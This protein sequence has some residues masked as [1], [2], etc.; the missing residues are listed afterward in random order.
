METYNQRVEATPQHEK[1]IENMNRELKVGESQFHALLDKK[2]DNSM[3][4][5]F[6]QSG[7]GIGFAVSEPASLPGGPYSPQ[8]ARL[9]LMGLAAGLG[10]GLVVAFVLEQNDTTFGTVDDFQAFT[11]LPILGI[12]PNIQRIKRRKTG[13]TKSP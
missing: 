13:Q 3:A 4:K 5:G 11:S 10:L 12:I 6:E 2:L 1:M 7:T 8:R 9:A